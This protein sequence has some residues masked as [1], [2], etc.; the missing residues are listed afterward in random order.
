ML[1]R[2][3]DLKS[4]FSALGCSEEKIMCYF[5]FIFSN[6]ERIVPI[7]ISHYNRKD[8]AFNSNANSTIKKNQGF[9]FFFTYRHYQELFL[10]AFFSR[11]VDFSH[12]GNNLATILVNTFYYF[13]FPGALSVC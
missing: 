2:E 5:L 3:P 1:K 7:S 10:E 9:Y 4:L 8:C 6:L 12:C 11:N 13:T